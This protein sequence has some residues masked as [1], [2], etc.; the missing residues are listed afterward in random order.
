M[1]QFNHIANILIPV[2]NV[3]EVVRDLRSNGLE[4]SNDFDFKVVAVAEYDD[5]NVPKHDHIRFSFRES[6]WTSYVILKYG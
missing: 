5:Y 2:S 6:K 4:I 3:I 1:S